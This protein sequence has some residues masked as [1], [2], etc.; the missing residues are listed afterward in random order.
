MNKERD[1]SAITPELR[2]LAG[3][4]CRCDAVDPELYTKYDVKRGLRDLNG[5]GVVAGLTE[6]SEIVG[7]SVGALKASY[8]HAVRKIEKY[9][10]ERL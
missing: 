7:T 8:H 10:E 1:F 3:L 6:I 4:C 5:K 9:I 2:R